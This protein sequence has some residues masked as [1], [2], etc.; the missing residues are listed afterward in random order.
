MFSLSCLCSSLGAF[1]FFLIFFYFYKYN[2]LYSYFISFVIISFCNFILQT[3]MSVKIADA[4]PVPIH[5]DLSY[6]A[7][8]RVTTSL[9]QLQPAL[10]SIFN[11]SWG[12]YGE[13]YFSFETV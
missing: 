7:V 13:Q 5:Q 3:K 4:T 2:Q 6:V 8:E 12:R 1:G 9:L 11:F 10:V